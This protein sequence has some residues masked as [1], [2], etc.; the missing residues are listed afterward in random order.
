MKSLK[1]SPMD[2][3]LALF[4]FKV[5]HLPALNRDKKVSDFD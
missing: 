2:L 3:T 1:A 4:A 5:T